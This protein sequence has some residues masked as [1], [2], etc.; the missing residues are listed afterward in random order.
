D[1]KFNNTY[2][3]TPQGGIISPILS[4]IYL[5][6]LDKYIEE[7]KTLFDKGTRRQNNI[8]YTQKYKRLWYLKKK[9]ADR[10][11]LAPHNELTEIT[12]E[13]KRLQKDIR[14]M[15]SVE[16]MDSSFKRIQY[17]RYADDFLIGIIGSKQDAEEVKKDLTA[18]L[19]NKLNL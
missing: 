8:V 18:F 17:V 15:S 3:G 9:F 19:K 10:K 14:T 11:V 1:W 13:V 4:N 16:L 2:S 6:E 5:N 7:Y 12:S